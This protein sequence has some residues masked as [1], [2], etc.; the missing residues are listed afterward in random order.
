MWGYEANWGAFAQFSRV[1]EVQL[2]AAPPEYN[3]YEDACISATGV[4]AYRM[5]THWEGN[6]LQKGDVVLVW[7]GAGGRSY[8]HPAG[9]SF[10]RHSDCCGI[11]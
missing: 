1:L 11:Q 10:G 2:L 9:T 5:L 8:R 4:T 7:G 6:Q 3:W